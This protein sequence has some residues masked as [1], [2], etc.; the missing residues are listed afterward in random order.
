ML[1]TACFLAE[2]RLQVPNGGSTFGKGEVH[3]KI[4]YL[5]KRVK[6]YRKQFQKVLTEN[7]ASLGNFTQKNDI[8]KLVLLSCSY[9]FTI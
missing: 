3:I 9:H 1:A 7:M 2:N 4:T 5:A 8:L 6:I